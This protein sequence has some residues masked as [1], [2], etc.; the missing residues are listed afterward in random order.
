M[1]AVKTGEDYDLIDPHSGKAVGRLPAGEIFAQITE[2]A[3]R[4]G[5]P[6]M[7]FIDRMNRDNPT[8]QIGLIE[9]TNPCGEQPLLPNEAC[10]LGSINLKLMAAEDE[11]K[12]VI[13]WERLRTVT[14][15]AVRFLDDVIDANQYPL[16]VI[17]EMVKGNRK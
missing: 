1:E 2:H 11:G 12:A 5:E 9:A 7:V 17:E 14:R 8:P 16:P 3:W 4:N 6:G 13:N 15:L 10:N